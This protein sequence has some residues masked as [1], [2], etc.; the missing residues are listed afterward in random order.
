MTRPREP[1][2]DAYRTARAI[3]LEEGSTMAFAA[4]RADEAAIEEAGAKLICRIAEAI[5]EAER[6]AVAEASEA[7]ATGHPIDVD[8]YLRSFIRC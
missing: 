4:R 3:V 8:A 1:I 2:A 6:N 7:A 5:L